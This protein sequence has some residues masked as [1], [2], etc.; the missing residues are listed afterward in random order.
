MGAI[1]EKVAAQLRDPESAQFRNLHGEKTAT[2]G[3][4]NGK[5]AFGAY[6]G[7]RRF[8]HSDGSTI[9]ESEEPVRPSIEEM[10]AYYNAVADFARAERRCY[11]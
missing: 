5:N 9:F 3:E 7:F 11:K 4:V 6:V 8:V 2:C 10:T 1:E